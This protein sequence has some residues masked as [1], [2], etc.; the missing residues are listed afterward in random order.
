MNADAFKAQQRE[1]ALVVSK[2]SARRARVH[3]AV[4]GNF[5]CRGLHVRGTA[6]TAH[7]HSLATLARQRGA[8]AQPSSPQPPKEI[9]AGG[10]ERGPRRVSAQRELQPTWPVRR[11]ILHMLLQRG[12]S[13]DE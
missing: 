10:G 11:V 1:L 12:A 6:R 7:C 9:D 3:N 4:K 13:T 2:A 8:A 5:L